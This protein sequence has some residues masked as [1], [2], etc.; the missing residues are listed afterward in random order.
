MEKII[1]AAVERGASDIHVKGG[2]FVRARINGRLVPLT[3]QKLTPDHSRAFAL[4]VLPNERARSQIDEMM[5]FDCSWGLSG[6]GRFRVNIMR[7]RGS[8][9]VILRVIPFEV[10]TLESLGLPTVVERM[11]LAERGL[12]LVTGVTGSGKTSTMA[13]MIQHMNQHSERHI[14]TLEDPIEFL[15]RDNHCSISQ[16]EVGTDTDSFHKGLRAALRQDPDVILIGEMRDPETIEIALKAA[17]TGHLVISTLHTKDATNTI[18]RLIAA[19]PTDEQNTVRLRLSDALHGVISQRLLPR[20]E[21]QGRAVAAEVMLRTGTIEDCIRDPERTT[22]IRD[23]IAAGRE[24]YGMQTFD[25]HLAELVR[26]GTVSFEVARAAASN[27]GDFDL[28]A[29]LAAPSSADAD[30]SGIMMGSSY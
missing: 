16:R 19:F 18:S 27:P 12:V 14:V 1:A 13:A 10:P 4:K 8:F 23:H 7:Q 21:G 15:H 28:H 29:R 26:T 30:L 17:E 2:D 25:Q 6:T 24:N 22:E 3:R 5:D 11:A 20:A 9:N